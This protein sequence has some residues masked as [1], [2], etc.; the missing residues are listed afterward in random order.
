M[1]F[2]HQVICSLTAV[3]I[4][5]IS[6]LYLYNGKDEVA[7]GERTSISAQMVAIVYLTNMREKEFQIQ[8]FNDE[9]MA[10]YIVVAIYLL[11]T[12]RPFFA[13]FVLSLAYSV[14]AGA[15]LLIP[16]FAGSLQLFFG[17]RTLLVC[18]TFIVGF[19]IVVSLPFV[20]GDSTVYD[21]IVRSKLLGHGRQGIAFAEEF[22]DYLAAHKTLSILWRF[23]PDKYYYDRNYLSFYTKL[24]L[25]TLNVFFFFVRKNALWGCLSNLKEFLQL[26]ADPGA[27]L[28]AKQRQQMIEILVVQYFCGIMMMPG[29]HGQF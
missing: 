15:L 14:K 19:Q 11:A 2:V 25:P 18:L 9:I 29:A 24:G 3:F 17:T 13:T 12:S 10:F 21:Y 6:Y 27:S 23:V 16:A 7:A 26:R 5:K 8:M 28:T 4:T 1:R 22:W 20:L